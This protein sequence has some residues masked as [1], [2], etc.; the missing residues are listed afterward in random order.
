LYLKTREMGIPVA[1]G[2]SGQLDRNRTE[3]GD[4]SNTAAAVSPK[5]RLSPG[6]RLQSQM[7]LAVEQIMAGMHSGYAFMG[8]RNQRR[9]IWLP[10]T[11]R[12]GA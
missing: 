6:R 2:F 9:S 1:D 10:R 12:R 8:R 5:N 4:F 7:P 3:P 11:S